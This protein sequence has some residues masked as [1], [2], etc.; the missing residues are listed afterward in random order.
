MIRKKP[1]LPY[2]HFIS[3]IISVFINVSIGLFLLSGCKTE[4]QAHHQTIADLPPLQV[5]VIAAEESKPLRQ[6]EVMASVKAS[7]SATIAARISGNIS[8]LPVK[9]G[10]NVQQGD[11]LVVIS[12]DETRA[13]LNQAQAQLDQADRNLKRERNLLKK[14][15]A[16]QESVRTLEE[17]RT[18]AAA[19]YKEAQTMLDY[20]V[21][22]APFAG[23]ITSKP[24][25]IGDLAVPGKP[26]LTIENESSLQVIADIPEALVLGLAI[27]DQLSVRVDAAD[28]DIQGTI[29]EIA[30]TA[31]PRSRTAPI[32]LDI[33]PSDKLRSG[34]FARV[35]LPGTTGSAIMI[36]AAS[37]RPFGQLERVFIIDDNTARLQLVKTGLLHGENIEVL[38]GVNGGDKVVVSD[39]KELSDGRKVTIN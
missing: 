24:A 28:L 7:Q 11:T 31:D 1:T 38:S 36:P 5:S 9:L 35:S 18:I 14:N 21:I 4:E 13:K 39:T 29:T 2:Q 22:K 23:I 16:T 26:L 6:V 8:E 3:V 19:A 27:G 25:N 30:P 37:I 33:E 12:A 20:T 10:D 34:Q 32:K 17:S 15:A